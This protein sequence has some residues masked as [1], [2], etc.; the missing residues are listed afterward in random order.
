LA[1]K[2]FPV[3]FLWGFQGY[4]WGNNFLNFSELFSGNLFTDFREL[5]FKAFLSLLE[6]AFWRDF[7]SDFS[8]Q[9]LGDFIGTVVGSFCP[10]CH[11][12]A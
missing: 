7:Y 2:N 5:I 1:S 3:S 10:F 6:T 9:F 4:F 11:Y 12:T 8:W